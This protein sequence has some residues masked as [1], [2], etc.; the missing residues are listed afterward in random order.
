MEKIIVE[1]RSAEGGMDSKLLA[2][3]LADVYRKAARVE[4][5][6]IS[7]LEEREGLI[8]LCL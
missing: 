5:F 4:N 1:I 3:D 8:S 7:T 6:S 2:K